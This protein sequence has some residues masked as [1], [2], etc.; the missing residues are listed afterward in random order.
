MGVVIPPELDG[1]NRQ[2]L[3]IPQNPYR[4]PKEFRE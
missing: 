2:T 1:V 4:G 3:P